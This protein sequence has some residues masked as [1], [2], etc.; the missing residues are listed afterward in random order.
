M[1]K[2][3][4]PF[5]IAMYSGTILLCFASAARLPWVID[6]SWEWCHLAL[7]VIG[8]G[9]SSVLLF[10]A[11]LNERRWRVY[12]PIVGRLDA[13]YNS[14]QRVKNLELHA[15]ADT[16]GN[17]GATL[18]TNTD[19]VEALTSEVCVPMQG[20][21][22]DMVDTLKQSIDPASSKALAMLQ[23]Q[24]RYHR[25]QVPLQSGWVAELYQMEDDAFVIFRRNGCEVFGHDP[26]YGVY[27]DPLSWGTIIESA[28][29]KPRHGAPTPMEAMYDQA[30]SLWATQPPVE[31]EPPSPLFELVGIDPLVVKALNSL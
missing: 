22:M 1:K 28:S 15:L 31:G 26:S 13:I 9:L 29:L 11:I 17:I 8:T 18:I 16:L 21:M 7:C 4:N 3:I 27:S 2:K 20:L 6:T 12:E 24:M 5:L 10:S 30:V 14:I 19:Q 23:A 25:E